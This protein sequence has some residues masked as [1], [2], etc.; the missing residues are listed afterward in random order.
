MR[1]LT[2]KSSGAFWEDSRC[3]KWSK[4]HFSEIVAEYLSGTLT[5]CRFC[6]D[7][8]FCTNCVQCIR[9]LYCK[10]CS[11]IF[12]SSNTVNAHCINFGDINV[13]PRILDRARIR[14]LGWRAAQS[15]HIPETPEPIYKAP[16][17][18][19]GADLLVGN[20]TVCTNMDCD[21]DQQDK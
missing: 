1:G 17:C 7:C 5:G 6:I 19:C 10:V 20:V 9:C 12:D 16:K 11:Y 21:I 15:H 8:A 4:V 3:N 13:L 18:K 14:F 2:I